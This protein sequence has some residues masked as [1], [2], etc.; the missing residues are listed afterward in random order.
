M[1]IAAGNGAA[2]RT[3]ITLVTM[4][5]FWAGCR[6][7]VHRRSEGCFARERPVAEPTV[8]ETPVENPSA[9]YNPFL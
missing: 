2:A 5:H 8:C 6:L 1:P 9:V 4:A 7:P 3:Q